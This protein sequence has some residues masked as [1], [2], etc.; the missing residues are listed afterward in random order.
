MVELQ[1]WQGEDASYAVILGHLSSKIHP[2]SQPFP[3]LKNAGGKLK[4]GWPDPVVQF[5][6][7]DIDERRLLDIASDNDKKTEAHCYLGLEHYAN[8]HKDAASREFDWVIQNGSRGFIEYG[9]AVNA[10]KWCATPAGR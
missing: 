4:S 6:R 1:G 9:I 5:L 3:F 10:V 2:Q 8:G 7:G